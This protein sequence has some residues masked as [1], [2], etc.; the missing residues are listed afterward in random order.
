MKYKQIKI[1]WMD[2]HESE[3]T[4]ANPTPPDKLQ[5]ATIESIGWLLGE[6][7]IMLEMTSHLSLDKDDNEQGRPMR[8]VK[9]AILYR[10]DKPKISP[11]RNIK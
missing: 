6:N 10:S 8:I 1:V 4:W 11:K 2:H 3:N 9:A 5:P 7:D